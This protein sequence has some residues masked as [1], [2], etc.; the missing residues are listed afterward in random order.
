MESRSDTIRRIFLEAVQ[1]PPEQRKQFIESVAGDDP[2]LAQHV[3]S[4]LTC[5]QTELDEL[6]QEAAKGDQLVGMSAGRWRLHRLIGKGGMGRVYLGVDDEGQEAAIKVLDRIDLTSSAHKRFRAEI[7]ALRTLDHPGIVRLIDWGEATLASRPIPY[8]ATEFIPSAEPIIDFALASV[9]DLDGRCRLMET[10]CDAVAHAHEQKIVHRDLKQEN[11]L[12]GTDGA[13]QVIDFGI[14]RLAATDHPS[15][16]GM[17]AE[18]GVLGSLTSMAPEQCDQSKGP[19]SPAT[20]VYALGTVLYQLLCGE[21]PYSTTGSIASAMQAVLHVPPTDPRAMNAEI[22]EPI[23]AVLLRALAKDPADRPQDAAELG[24]ELARARTSPVAPPPPPSAPTPPKE[25]PEPLKPVELPTPK[26]PSGVRMASWGLKTL[27]IGILAI[28]VISIFYLFFSFL[29]PSPPA[30]TARGVTAEQNTLKQE[31]NEMTNPKN[32]IAALALASTMSAAADINSIEEWGSSI[33]GNGHWYELQVVE[34]G[35]TWNQ[36]NAIAQSKG[37][38]LATIHSDAENEFARALYAV[39][40]EASIGDWGPWIGGNANGVAWQWVTTGEAWT[41]EAWAP[42]EPGSPADTKAVGFWND[43][44]G[45]A[46]WADHYES[47]E[48]KAFIIE[49]EGIPNHLKRVPQNYSTIQAAIQAASDGDLIKLSVGT[50]NERINFNGKA[51]TIYGDAPVDQIR[52]DG[53]GKG[54]VVQF[55]SGENSDSILRNVTITN[56]QSGGSGCN[57]YGGAIHASDSSPTIMDCQFVMNHSAG[58]G[59]CLHATNGA[60]PLLIN[61]EFRNT[62]GASVINDSC[63]GSSRLVN[64]L[65]QNNHVQHQYY[66]SSEGHNVLRD[67]TFADC[68]VPEGGSV[69]HWDR[70]QASGLVEGCTFEE[71]HFLG[72]DHIFYQAL[73]GSPGASFSGC[74]FQCV[75]TDQFEG[76]WNNAGENVFDIENCTCMGDIDRDGQVSGSDLSFILAGWGPTSDEFPQFDL[77]GDGSVNGADLAIVLGLWGICGE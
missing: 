19:M 9:P 5:I 48:L 4:L 17:T 37:G 76:P 10:V 31:N 54:P 40:P 52:I 14:A 2:D 68:K 49:Y 12:V 42:G 53:G 32:T 46:S 72:S 45:P 35:V 57:A 24:A 11:I 1:T 33:G 29:L 44:T 71:V 63:N 73:N 47:T 30:T 62:T 43:T 70:P 3:A 66:H 13:P 21:G 58:G 56:G 22:S 67:C 27:A 20:D 15:L 23:A 41:Y 18:H 7:T 65:F 51:I 61:C 39:N 16:Q 38:Y 50:Y 8:L 64:C 60:D 36:A 6:D 25:V 28:V 75:D 59:G 55:V 77:N 34:S 26:V 69:L 74:T